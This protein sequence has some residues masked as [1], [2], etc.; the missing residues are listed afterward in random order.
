[1]SFDL[2]GWF[3]GNMMS[4]EFLNPVPNPNG[5]TLTF[6]Q[7][8][9]NGD[10]GYPCNSSRLAEVYIYCGNSTSNCLGVGNSPNANCLISGGKLS[11]GF[12]LCNHLYNDSQSICS[13]ISFH[14]LVTNCP[15]K[16]TVNLPS[17]PSGPAGN[18]AGAVIGSLIGVFLFL[19]FIGYMYNYLVHKKTGCAAIPF[20]D[21]CTGKH[22]TVTYSVPKD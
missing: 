15:P 10:S 11:N 16:Q 4:F 5:P 14:V 19:F 2:L 12:C 13:G 7:L 6:R 1:M 21:T 22:S 8:Y 20:Y 17:R 9:G 3:Y 18:P